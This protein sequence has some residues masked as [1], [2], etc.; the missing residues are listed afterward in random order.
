MFDD[1]IQLLGLRV[2]YQRLSAT[3]TDSCASFYTSRRKLFRDDDVSVD[4]GVNQMT[5]LI[6]PNG[7]SDA[8]QAV[9]LCV[10]EDR[11]LVVLVLQGPTLGITSLGF[12]RELSRC[13]YL[14][15]DIGLDPRDVLA[16]AVAPLPQ[17][18]TPLVQPLGIPDPQ[19]Q[20]RG[21]VAIRELID[22]QG[23]LSYVKQTEESEMA[24]RFE[25]TANK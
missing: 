22:L 13:L 15:L 7:A 4:V 20:K 6:T 17:Q 14:T 5:V 3:K 9:L 16:A 23:R 1:V 24:F 11:L 12:D 25:G 10:H 2:I 21:A 19:E 18:H 8:H